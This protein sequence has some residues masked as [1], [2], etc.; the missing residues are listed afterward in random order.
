MKTPIIHQEKFEAWLFAQP[1]TRTFNYS[2][3]TDC[4]LCKFLKETTNV[5]QPHVGSN[6]YGAYDFMEENQ[7]NPMPDFVYKT[8][9]KRPSRLM[10][11][12]GTIQAIYLELFPDSVTEVSP[13]NQTQTHETTN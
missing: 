3:I 6:T 10:L 12:F 9:A 8:L 2:D 7:F 11:D 1:S 13:T 5:K 4:L